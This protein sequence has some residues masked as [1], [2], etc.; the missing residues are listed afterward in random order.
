[1]DKARVVIREEPE[2]VKKDWAYWT[3]F[4]LGYISWIAF[5]T[6]AAV[7]MFFYFL[8]AYYYGRKRSRW[9]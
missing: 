9:F 6:V 3:G 2:E 8:W 7:F 4:I 1:M 5:Y